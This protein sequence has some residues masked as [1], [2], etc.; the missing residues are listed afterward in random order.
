MARKPALDDT[1]KALVDAARRDLAAYMLLTHRTDMAEVA[2]GQAAPA[3]HHMKIIDPLMSPWLG[4]LNIVAPRDSAKTTL[5]Q[6]YLE[7][8]LGKASL[9]LEDWANVARFGYVSNAET[10]ATRVSNGIKETIE[11]NDWYHL[12]FPKVKRHKSKWSENE[13]KV[14]GNTSKD[15]NFVATGVHGS[16]LGVRFLEIV[17]DDVFGE[18]EAE[19]P[20]E[21]RRLIGEPGYRD[22]VLDHV[23]A[24]MV[25]PW[26]RSINV[27]TR[28]AEDDSYTWGRDQ[29]WHEIYMRALISCEDAGC[30]GCEV[31]EH[32][33]WPERY[34]VARLQQM[35]KENP[36]RFARQYQ[37]DIVPVEGI[38]FKREWFR[39]R[40]DSA[41]S[42]EEVRHVFATWDTAGTLT[43]RSYT[44][45]LVVVV[46]KDW[47]YLV[48]H[49]FRGRVEY[50]DLKRVIRE[51]AKRWKVSATVIEEKSTGQPALQELAEE[52]DKT[53][54]TWQRVIPV[55][56]PGQRGGPGRIDWVEQIT[57]PLEECR[58]WL[59]T[60]D[61][62]AGQGVEDWT[63]TFLTEMLSYPE[64]SNDDI[65]V[66]LTQLLFHIERDRKRWEAEDRRRALGPM[67]WG[68]PAEQYVT[69]RRRRFLERQRA[70]QGPEKKLLV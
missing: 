33:Y 3:A 26:G 56:P 68:D 22:G 49:M 43:G 58:L 1:T 41:P 35:R 48:L 69:P 9:E 24:P 70:R 2:D 16:A 6:F 67:R 27:S 66:A 11:G 37:N 39:N 19:S 7:W 32:S 47:D 5:I 59:P 61:F 8:K 4:D 40:F 54:Y 57:I 50:P 34:P 29:G 44:V 55:L 38:T 21:R 64:G 13:W 28:W 46:T 45:G 31:G 51:T 12:I 14:Q 20:T 52:Y 62:L 17:Y 53:R 15:S 23:F 10:Q 65:V 18:K 60:P 42:P 30:A 63:G 36:L 25:V